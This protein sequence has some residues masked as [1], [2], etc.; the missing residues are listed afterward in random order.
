M[1]VIDLFLQWA[2][3]IAFISCGVCCFYSNRLISEFERYGFESWRKLIA[4]LEIAGGMGLLI[5]FQSELLRVLSSASLAVLMLSAILVRIK[6]YDPFYAFL[7]AIA[8]FLINVYL[9]IL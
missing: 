7:P 5:G 2:S 6:I 1:H 8:L 4:V 9:A 3:I